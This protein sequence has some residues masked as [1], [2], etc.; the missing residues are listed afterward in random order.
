MTLEE[1][2]QSFARRAAGLGDYALLTKTEL[3]NGYCDAE[4]EE[5]DI[6]MDEYWSAIILRYWYK[7]YGWIESCKSLHLEATEY[8]NWLN[9]ALTVAFQYRSW[10]PTLKDGSPNPHYYEQD[11]NVA[12]RSINFFCGTWR[13][14]VYQ[15]MNKDKRRVNVLTTSLEQSVEDVGDA[16]LE[17]YGFYTEDP[18]IDSIPNIV[19]LFLDKGR[20]IEALIIDG[21]AYGDSQREIKEKKTVMVSSYYDNDEE[22]DS[23]DD[24]DSLDALDEK[25]YVEEE[26]EVNTY[27]YQ[28]DTR[29][30]VKHLNEINQSYMEFFATKYDVSEERI[31]EIYNKLK[32]L[33]NSKLYRYIKK[34]LVNLKSDPKVLSMIS[35]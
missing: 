15:E 30:L 22:E 33:N 14:R 27:S 4:A 29:K 23:L 9:D 1:M 24:E 3:A 25:T 18:E 12:D 20:D 8:V 5:D 31:E 2:K 13:G 16:A 21:I 10:R 35:Q 11:S 28:L 26:K 17:A 6:K 34:T 7:I 19:H 32:K